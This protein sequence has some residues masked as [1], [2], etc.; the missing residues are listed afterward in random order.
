MIFMLI[1]TVLDQV[2]LLTYSERWESSIC[3]TVFFFPSLRLGNATLYSRRPDL[4]CS[5]PVSPLSFLLPQLEITRFQTKEINI[6]TGITATLYRD[7]ANRVH[8][9]GLLP[10]SR[11]LS[12]LD[13]CLLHCHVNNYSRR[14]ADVMLIRICMRSWF[15]SGMPSALFI[16]LLHAYTIHNIQIVPHDSSVTI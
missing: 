7:L 6:S 11:S 16:L 2:T 14:D 4:F 9:T 15:T 1:S 10:E 13:E 8:V 12:L 3:F 5:Q